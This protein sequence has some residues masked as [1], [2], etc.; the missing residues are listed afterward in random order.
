M[1]PTSAS[2]GQQDGLTQA[3]PGY[4]GQSLP[5]GRGKI[6]TMERITPFLPMSTLGSHRQPRSALRMSLPS[7]LFFILL[8]LFFCSNVTSSWKYPWL[9]SLVFYFLP[10]ELMEELNEHLLPACPPPD[11]EPRE[12]R[13]V[14]F[15]LFCWTPPREQPCLAEG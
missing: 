14:P 1:H 15:L 3:L 13:A 4:R 5:L 8:S 2:Q 7:K 10:L 12:G 6:S 9:C 11:N